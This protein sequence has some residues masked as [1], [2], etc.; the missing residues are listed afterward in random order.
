[1][2]HAKPALAL[3]PLLALL[4]APAAPAQAWKALG[5]PGDSVTAIAIDPKSPK[6]LWAGTRLGIYKSVDG[7]ATWTKSSKGLDER[8]VYGLVVDPVNPKTLYAAA[9]RGGLWKSVDGGAT[10]KS[11]TPAKAA[12][13]F[14]SQVQ[15]RS[16][17]IDPS[18][19]KNLIFGALFKSADGAAT[20]TEI[21]PPAYPSGHRDVNVLAFDPRNGKVIWS[22]DT[23]NLHRST[24][25]GVSWKK[26]DFG[27]PEPSHV[28]A[29]AVHPKDSGTVYIGTRH[30][31]FFH[32]SDGG[33]TWEESESGLDD[34]ASVRAIALDPA[35]PKR[36]YVA[37]N[38]KSTGNAMSVFR[39]EDGGK[40]F[41]D[42]GADLPWEPIDAL[43]LDPADPKTMY[44]G[45][46]F[47]GV[48]VTHDGGASWNEASRGLPVGARTVSAVA[49]YGDS[50]FATTYGAVHRSDDGGTTWRRLNAGFD[51][52]VKIEQL[53]ATKGDP[54]F[55][56]AGGKNEALRWSLDG[57]ATWDSPIRARGLRCLV[58][59]PKEPGTLYACNA[60]GGIFRIRNGGSFTRYGDEDLTSTLE[61]IAV[62]PAG[63]GTVIVA[64][65]SVGLR[66]STNAGKKWKEFNK[67][68]T[69]AKGSLTSFAEYRRFFALA[70]SPAEP[71][72]IYGATEKEGVWK[73]G[74]AGETWTAAGLTDEKLTTFA[75]DPAN[76]KR[77]AAGTDEKGVLLSTDGGSS[78][79]NVSDGL[80]EDDR[81]R[82]ETI[83]SITFGGGSP[84]RLYV[85]V[86]DSGVYGRD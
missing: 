81:K 73:S 4:G 46:G 31:G 22:G 66:R 38:L 35:D 51:K 36:L 7:A 24:D 83:H 11:T 64:D 12:Y 57:G 18:N 3:L 60:D 28:I 59:D 84:S 78:W 55:V 17:A 2:R 69:K 50:L 85:G 67:G 33:K 80:P 44:A 6:T 52:G 10:W 48:Y 27:M 23:G 63:G 30:N 54:V 65:S 61:A 71:R 43:V 8:T 74:D 76:P 41:E 9:R 20:W 47:S 86:D 1:M 72:T 15:M 29:V 68:I 79:T 62:D 37:A 25:F 34:K 42:V 70:W 16:V 5:P 32:T 26:V 14:A 82:K 45:T 75:M 58:P 39:S 49:A 53:A 56:V 77:L 19:P 21:D 40:S 13:S